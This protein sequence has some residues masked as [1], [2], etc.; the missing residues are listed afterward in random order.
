ME[1]LDKISGIIGYAVIKGEDGSIEEVKGSSTAPLGDLTAFFSSAG[2]VI[3]TNLSLGNVNYISLC[4][5]ANRLVI[6]PLDA[7][8]LG[9][10]NK[11][12]RGA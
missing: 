4:Y 2:E 6:F 11:K 10:E 3:K 7:K 5:G 8:Y 1:A 12:G 9:M